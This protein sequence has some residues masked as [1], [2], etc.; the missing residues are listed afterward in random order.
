VKDDFCFVRSGSA[1]AE[2]ATRGVYTLVDSLH[3]FERNIPTGWKLA[4]LL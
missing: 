2:L 3:D 1:A 4:L